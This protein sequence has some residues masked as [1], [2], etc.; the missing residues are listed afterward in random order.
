MSDASDQHANG[1][2]VTHTCDQCHWYGMNALTQLQ[3]KA[4][5]LFSRKIKRIEN[6]SVKRV[7]NVPEWRIKATLKYH[8]AV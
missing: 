3:S 1:D 6:K 7:D 2:V 8:I 5:Y 4:E